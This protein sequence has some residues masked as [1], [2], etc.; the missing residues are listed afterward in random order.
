MAARGR[1]H[2]TVQFVGSVKGQEVETL[3]YNECDNLQI[4]NCAAA[5]NLSF[6]TKL[7]R[8]AFLFTP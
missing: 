6:R 2:G 1:S 3:G 8:S 4:G 5:V 7:A